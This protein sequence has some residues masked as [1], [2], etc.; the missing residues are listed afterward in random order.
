MKNCVKIRSMSD[1]H[2]NLVFKIIVCVI[3]NLMITK[4]SS[5]SQTLLG[6]IFE[7]HGKYGLKD[8]IFL[9]YELFE[10]ILPPDSPMI[11]C[12]AKCENDQVCVSF[13]YNKRSRLCKGHSEILTSVMLTVDDPGTNVFGESARK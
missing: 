12:A 4:T 5:I 11:V 9:D 2:I 3:F 8:V 1:I 6:R 13:T 10:T 7:N